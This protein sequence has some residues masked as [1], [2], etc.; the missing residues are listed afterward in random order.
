MRE[1]A[2]KRPDVT[3]K[4]AGHV[5]SLGM[6]VFVGQ[7]AK[8]LRFLFPEAGDLFQAFECEFDSIRR[9]GDTLNGDAPVDIGFKCLADSEDASLERFVLVNG[10]SAGEKGALRIAEGISADT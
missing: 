5:V 1:F 8:P 10:R 9:G 6:D 3:K 7:R 4:G 2:N